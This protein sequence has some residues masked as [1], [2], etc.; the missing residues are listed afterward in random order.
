M[1]G[2]ADFASSRLAIS[3]AV[4]WIRAKAR[5]LER[6][7]RWSLGINGQ[8]SSTALV[9]AELGLVPDSD[10]V[11]RFTVGVLGIDGAWPAQQRLVRATS[12]RGENVS[13]T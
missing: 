8:I 2:I 5:A 11:A 6:S 3:P 4:F 9:L 1:M 13:A 12:P 10:R 7:A